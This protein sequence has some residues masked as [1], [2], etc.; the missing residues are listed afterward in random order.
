MKLI[1]FGTAG[2]FNT[3]VDWGLYF[4]LTHAIHWGVTA[5]KLTG[6]LGGISSAFLLNAL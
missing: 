5:S 3:G 1:K 2:I 4:L 6:S